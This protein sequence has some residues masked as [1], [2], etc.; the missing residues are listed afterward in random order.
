MNSEQKEL[1]KSTV[2]LWQRLC[3]LHQSLLEVTNNEYTALLSS[4]LDSTTKILE[5]KKQLIERIN[6]EEHARQKIV[7]E[8]LGP[9]TLHESFRFVDLKKFFNQFE[10]E[11]K[12]NH[13]NNFNLIL[14]DTIA[15][16]KKQNKKNQYFINRALMSLDGLKLPSE[17]NPNHSIYNKSGKKMKRLDVKGV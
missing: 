15:K 6:K 5:Q 17:Q 12:G 1:Y 2:N 10:I 7:S 13:L 11:S 16:I 14:L 4:D 9:S 8:V 3:N